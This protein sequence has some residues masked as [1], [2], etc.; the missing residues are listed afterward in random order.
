MPYKILLSLRLTILGEYNLWIRL[1]RVYVGKQPIITRQNMV[2]DIIDGES[3]PLTGR[4]RKLEVR[5]SEFKK[6][7]DNDYYEFGNQY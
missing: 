6:I 3:Y 2:Q 5:K 7:W 1:W 4:E